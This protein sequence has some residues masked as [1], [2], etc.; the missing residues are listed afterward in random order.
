MV[1]L[2][3]HSSNSLISSLLLT[4]LSEKPFPIVPFAQLTVIPPNTII[5]YYN[6][7]P[8]FPWLFLHLC[9]HHILRPMRLCDKQSV[10]EQLEKTFANGLASD[11]NPQ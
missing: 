2:R 1:I 3:Q 6:L 11:H 9:V 4:H 7:S 10:R 5:R 8:V